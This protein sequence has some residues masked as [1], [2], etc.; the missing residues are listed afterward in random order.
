MYHK[1]F[2]LFGYF[3][4]KPWAPASEMVDF[5]EPEVVQRGTAVTEHPLGEGIVVHNRSERIL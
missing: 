1:H 4:L 2:T 5:T 3:L